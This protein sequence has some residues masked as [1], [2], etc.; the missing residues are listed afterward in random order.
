MPVHLERQFN[1]GQRGLGKTNTCNLAV[2]CHCAVVF[3]NIL[4]NRKTTWNGHLGAVFTAKYYNKHRNDTKISLSLHLIR[5]RKKIECLR[6][7]EYK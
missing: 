7:R 5:E 2:E 3:I 6:R 4:K 1:F